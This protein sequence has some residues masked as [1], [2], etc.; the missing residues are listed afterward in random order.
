MII[1][2]IRGIFSSFFQRYNDD[3]VDRLY[4]LHTVVGL[5]I[6]VLF[7]T[8]KSYYGEPIQCVVNNNGEASKF[9]HSM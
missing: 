8:S 4:Y 1:Q 9:I 3:S 2:E 5:S 7:I 6:Y